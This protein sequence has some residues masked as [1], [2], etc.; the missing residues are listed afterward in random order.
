MKTRH[1]LQL[2]LALAVIGAPV[3]AQALTPA[4][5]FA[6]VAPSVWVVKALQPDPN[7]GVMGSAVVLGPRTLVTACHVVRSSVSVSVT[8]SGSQ[9]SYPIAQITPDPS[10]ARDL[11][12]LT[13][14][15][16]ISGPAVDVAPSDS[17]K[18]GNKV[19]AIGAPLG[20][21]LTLSDGLVSSLRAS[22]GEALPTI[23]SS[24]PVA[25]GSSG[26]GLFD[27]QG[28]L[29]GLTLSTAGA[30]TATLNFSDPA[31]WA[32]EVP[33]RIEAARQ[34]WRK[35]ITA[36][37][38]TMGPDGDA[39]PSGYAV[40]GDIGKVPTAGMPSKGVAEAYQQFLLLSKPRAFLVTS[41]HQWGAVS[42]AAALAEQFKDC[43]TRHATC[44]L[45]AVDDAVVWK[46]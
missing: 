15:E 26:G 34:A 7:H 11:C 24:A 19:F 10:V 4:E 22:P 1:T 9:K 32:L 36:L 6:K 35:Q 17:V 40:I 31:A 27:T 16:D 43:Q 21:E 37:G 42:D 45:Y 41:D 12:I 23:Q 20:L 25:P 14:T 13:T 3:A 2:A 39:A 33:A 28:R 18:V 29:I 44:R 8:H 5:V 38:V 46:P 30:G